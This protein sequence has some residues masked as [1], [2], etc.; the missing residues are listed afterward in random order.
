MAVTYGSSYGTLPT[1]TPVAGYEF[2]NWYTGASDGTKVTASTKVTNASSHTLYARYKAKTYI[3]TFNANGGTC[4]TASKDVTY[5]AKYGT[6][7]TPTW[8][9]HTF[10][11]WYTASS[12]GTKITADSTVSITA[13]QTLYAQWTSATIQIS[14]AYGISKLEIAVNGSSWA[15]MNTGTTYNVTPGVTKVR[16]TSSYGSKT[17]W[18]LNDTSIGTM[19]TSTLTVPSGAAGPAVFYI[20]DGD[21][22]H[23]GYGGYGYDGRYWYRSSGSWWLA[24]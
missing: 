7:P 18:Y 19:A 15:T 4:A 1:A 13:G 2:T 23:G 5:G 9:N 24:Q 10:N 22:D 16:A 11:G 14:Y 21:G 6:L 3:V 17:Y 12:G 20:N 8:S